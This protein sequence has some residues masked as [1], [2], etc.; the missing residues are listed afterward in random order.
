MKQVAV[1]RSDYPVLSEPF[2]GEQ[3]SHYKDWK[4]FVLRRRVSMLET[5]HRCVDIGLARSRLI[6]A[7]PYSAASGHAEEAARAGVIHAHFGSD[8]VYAAA[9]AKAVGKPLVVTFHGF[10][11]TLTRLAMLRS[12][13]PSKWH[14]LCGRPRIFREAA[15]VV[16]VSEFVRRRLIAEGCDEAKVIR[17][18][19]GVDPDKFLPIN[20]SEA[21]E[22]P[23]RFV[24]VARL[25]A[26]KALD[27]A[28]KAVSRLLGSGFDCTLEIVGDGPLR[29]DLTH[30]INFLG[31]ADR[32]RLLGGMPHDQVTQIVRTGD[33]FLFPSRV[34]KDGAE[35][36]LG[37][38]MLEAAACE[39]PIVAADVGGIGEVVLH[40]I[41]GMLVR[42]DD[43]DGFAA[44]LASLARDPSLRRRMGKQGR[45]L[46][47]TTFDVRNQSPAL[48]EIYDEVSTCR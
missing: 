22:A 9:L 29:K 45:D 16:A 41:N 8:G 39:I 48:E 31:V 12:M 24:C 35:E 20:G 13:R 38:A 33:V 26:S 40:G 34:C 2:I 19:I 4:P 36:A 28:I 46:V 21:N 14:L 37:I 7:W 6:G 18:Y 5:R 11:A 17:H 3:I 32:V 25:V 1:I 23:L 15:K 10:D 42:Q 43:I 44:A 27:V 30:L 47:L